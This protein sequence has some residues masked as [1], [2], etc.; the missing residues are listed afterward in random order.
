MKTSELIGPALDW[1]A[2][3]A[4]G[5]LAVKPSRCFDCK[6]YEERQ[7]RDDA[8]QYCHHPKMNFVDG[9]EA[10]RTWPS[11]YETH[12]QCPITELTP[13]PLSTNWEQ[14]GPIIEREGIALRRGHS[15]WW[16]ACTLDIND[17]EHFMSISH[18]A[19]TAA[20]RCFVA[21][22]LG[23]EVEVPE[24]LNP[25]YPRST[26]HVVQPKENHM[27]ANQTQL[28][29]LHLIRTSDMLD[30]NR[31]AAKKLIMADIKRELGID[32]DA[33]IKVGLDT[34]KV[35]VK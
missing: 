20:M 16:I 27:N 3:K 31:K 26:T 22:K 19:L 34:G 1:A 15:G 8:I 29:L 5:T 6:H 30:D 12:E 21:S 28:D 17:D 18:N 11:D 4:N 23:D 33:K 32:P 2:N 9:S 13:E 7:G 24:E 25:Q 14:G 10:I 35:T